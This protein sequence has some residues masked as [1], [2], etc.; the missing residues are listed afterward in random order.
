MAQCLWGASQKVDIGLS[1]I[2]PDTKS[3]QARATLLHGEIPE[4]NLNEKKSSEVEVALRYKL[5]V[6]CL[7]SSM[8]A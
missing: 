8:Y 1:Q 2:G 4:A 5:L 3:C 6:H 7:N